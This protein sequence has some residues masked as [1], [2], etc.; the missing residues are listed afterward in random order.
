MSDADPKVP[1]PLAGEGTLDLALLVGAAA[2]TRRPALQRGSGAVA[3]VA[4][5][6]RVLLG[7][8]LVV[9]VATL[10]AWRPPLSR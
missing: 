1:S 2:G 5:K 7:L 6:R 9:L 10:V 3:E 4:M 8:G